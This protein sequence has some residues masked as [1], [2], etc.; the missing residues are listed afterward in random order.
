MARSSLRSGRIVFAWIEDRNGFG[1]LRPAV[2]ITSDQELPTV[3]RLVVMA[4]TTTF[5][6]PPPHFC[7]P[8]PWHPRGHPVTRLNRRSAAVVNWLAT[9]GVDDVVGYGGDVPAKIMH[10]I[11][12]KLGDL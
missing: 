12:E 9:I 8:L 7:V 1:K 11:D 4:I 5:P 3:E 2:V 6:D 10:V